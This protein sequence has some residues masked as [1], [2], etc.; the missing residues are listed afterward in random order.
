MSGLKV[1]LAGGIASGKS[2]VSRQ[3]EALGVTVHDTDIISR[4]LMQPG[5]DGFDQAVAHFGQHILSG[6]GTIDRSRLRQ[7][8]FEDSAQREWLE[9]MLHPRIR[10]E[11]LRLLSLPCASAYRVLVVPLMFESGFNELVDHVVAINCPPEV[12]HR[13]LVERDQIAPALARQMTS[14]QMSNDDRLAR[15]DSVLDNS[16]DDPDRLADAVERLH[17]SLL[18]LAAMAN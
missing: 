10:A 16:T 17:R 15:A 1:G 11:S 18:K 4:G 13:R 8:V 9:Q 3:L 12:Q 14:A 7:I 5:Q 2:T 6:E